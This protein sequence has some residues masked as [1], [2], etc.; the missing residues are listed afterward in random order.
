M[1][2]VIIPE[3]IIDGT[4]VL[5]L[6]GNAVRIDEGTITS[7]GPKSEIIKNLPQGAEI[8]DASGHTL[9]PGLIDAHVHVGFS[10]H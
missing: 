2:T 5:P 7:V 10:C 3:T 1:T 6:R 9:I 8:I 4:G